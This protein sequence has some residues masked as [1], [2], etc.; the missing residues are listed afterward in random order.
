MYEGAPTFPYPDS[1]WVMVDSW[2]SL[3]AMPP[4]PMMIQWP[5]RR[6]AWV[7]F[8]GCFGSH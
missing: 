3:L 8:V 1:W 2:S 5:C 6:M 7:S 4:G